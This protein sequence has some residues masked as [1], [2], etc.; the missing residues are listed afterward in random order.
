[1]EKGNTAVG[2]KMRYKNTGL[3]GRSKEFFEIYFLVF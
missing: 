2:K 1:M 3:E